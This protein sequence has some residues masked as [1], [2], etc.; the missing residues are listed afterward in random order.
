MGS[1][2]DPPNEFAPELTSLGPEHRSYVDGVPIRV[3]GLN[4]YGS[5]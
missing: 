5:S 4:G 3:A 2:L 1:T